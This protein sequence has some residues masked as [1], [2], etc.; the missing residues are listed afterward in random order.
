MLPVR[1]IRL[2]RHTGSLIREPESLIWESDSLIWEGDSVIRE[3]DSLIRE[4]SAQ[5]ADRGERRTQQRAAS[6]FELGVH[7]G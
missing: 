6:A 3:P 7:G 5:H 4:N 1:L 2:I